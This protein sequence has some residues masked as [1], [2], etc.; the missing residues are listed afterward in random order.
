MDEV[1][2]IS[3]EKTIG[4]TPVL[5][6]YFGEGLLDGCEFC[7]HGIMVHVGDVGDVTG[8]SRHPELIA[9]ACLACAAEK[10]QR[11]SICYMVSAERREAI[12]WR[13]DS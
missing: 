7:E 4:Y 12:G 8:E 9:L 13:G 1:V 5:E 2:V 6:A 3:M 10:G 11:Q